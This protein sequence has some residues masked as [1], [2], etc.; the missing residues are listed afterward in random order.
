MVCVL[1]N[2]ELAAIAPSMLCLF[3]RVGLLVSLPAGEPNLGSPAFFMD[4]VASRVGVCVVQFVSIWCF[5]SINCK[6]MLI[7]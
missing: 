3:Y 6:V 7:W 4:R 1:H 5:S 2:A